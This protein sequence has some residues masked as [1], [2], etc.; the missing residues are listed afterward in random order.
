MNVLKR[1]FV[2]KSWQQM[3]RENAGQQQTML[4]ERLLLQEKWKES[5]KDPIP[6]FTEYL[7]EH[8]E[9]LFVLLSE[10]E[11]EFLCDI[12]D[13]RVEEI[14]EDK[15]ILRN[16]SAL[17]KLGLVYYSRKESLLYVNEEAREH[18]Y[19]Y[20]MGR[21]AWEQVRKN[22]DLEYA[23]RGMLYQCGIIP[24]E[25]LYEILK[26]KNDEM[27]MSYEEFRQF[28]IGRIDL[29]QFLGIFRMI[30]EDR[31]YVECIDVKDRQKILK[32]RMMHPELS[33]YEPPT[34]RDAI[35][36]GMA[37]GI[38][39]WKGMD[40]L[41]AFLAR[42]LGGEP[43]KNTT[44]IV[45]FAKNI[46]SYIQSGDSIKE[47]NEKL[48]AKTDDFTEEESEELERCLDLLYWNTPLHV[49]KGHSRNEGEEKDPERQFSVINGGKK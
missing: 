16:I 17:K 30:Y 38:G 28:L 35:H 40:E 19:F 34:M 46:L 9:Q 44:A 2:D 27:T 22:Q 14:E 29:W 4:C 8:P 25:S 36:V 20:V 3:L 26:R 1:A 15:N 48:T 37:G 7:T 33:E 49:R 23:V 12:W 32:G 31:E 41:L 39:K 11:Y 10:A 24:V 45:V 47:I 21:S 13:E 43:E 18:F 5:V 6:F 42:I